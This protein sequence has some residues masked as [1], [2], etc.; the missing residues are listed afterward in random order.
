MRR[1]IISFSLYDQLPLYTV[2]AIRNAELVHEI[3]KE[4][5]A[6]FYVD[7]SISSD[8]RA[9][10]EIRGAEIV[11]INHPS[12]GPMYGRYWRLLVAAEAHVERFIVRD[13]DSR[14]NSREKAAVDAWIASDKTFHIM[15]DSVHHSRRML[16]GMWGGLGGCLP[17]ISRQ[18]EDW[19]RYSV[20][21]EC[22]QFMSEIV[23]PQTR[24]QH[25]CHDNHRHFDDAE[26][27]PRHDPMCETSF[28][29]EIVRLNMLGMDVWRCRGELLDQIA[30]LEK[31]LRFR[32]RDLLN[33]SADP[34]QPDIICRERGA[35]S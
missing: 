3:Y 28:V 4:W 17:E 9:A 12:K 15:R 10:L 1:R 32:N 29:G 24:D 21:G 26:P 14:L 35:E 22:D 34:R 13:V 33:V 11:T 30:L 18:I 25:L 16:A 31:Q 20:Q 8:V 27:F 7:E 2:G 5:I 19:G 23:Y 6:R